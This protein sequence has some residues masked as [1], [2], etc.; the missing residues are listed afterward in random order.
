MKNYEIL[1]QWKHVQ[2]HL[3]TSKW[4]NRFVQANSE[5]EAIQKFKNEN[6]DVGKWIKKIEST[7]TWAYGNT[8]SIGYDFYTN[9]VYAKELNP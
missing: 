8:F 3:A 5:D 1:Y 9:K 2:G 7:G 4:N 6:E